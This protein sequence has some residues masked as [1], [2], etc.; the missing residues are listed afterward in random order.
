MD[1]S[2]NAKRTLNWDEPQISFGMSRQMGNVPRELRQAV[3]RIKCN[4]SILA[5]AR[6]DQMFRLYLLT[7]LVDMQIKDNLTV[8]IPNNVKLAQIRPEQ[9]KRM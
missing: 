7:L 1:E 6:M 4:M 5:A 2:L 9:F 3:Q 8:I